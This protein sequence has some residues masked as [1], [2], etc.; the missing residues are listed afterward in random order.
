MTE[1]QLWNSI[2]QMAVTGK[3]V[4]QHPEDEPASALLARIETEKA[5]LIKEKKIKKEKNPTRIVRGENGGFFEIPVVEHSGRSEMGNGKWEMDGAIDISDQIP[6]E[7]PESWEWVRLGNLIEIIS[8]TSYKKHDITDSG[9]RILRG[10][11]IQNNK[12]LLFDDDVFLSEKSID[13]EKNIQKGDIIIVASTGSKA[14]IGKPAF[15][16]ADYPLTQIGAFLRII[17]PI[18]A[19]LVQYIN[20]IFQSE[21]YRKHI[22]DKVKGTNINNIKTEYIEEIFIPLSPLDEQKRIVEKL[23]EIA[24]LVSLY[25]EK[26]RAVSEMDANFAGSLKKSVLAAAVSGKLLPQDA[27]DEPAAALLA[28]IEAE[29]AAL[30]KAKKLKKEKNPTRIVRGKNGGFFEVSLSGHSGRSEMG[31]GKWEMDGA[32]DISDQLPFEIPES[33]EWVRLG[34]IV[35]NHGQKTPTEDFCYIDIGSI[36]NVHQK[37]NEKE[38]IISADKAPSR[39]RKIIKEGDILYATVRPYLHNM[40]IIDRKFSKEAI[41]ST[42]FA[43]LTCHADFLNYFLFYYLMS[44][45][46]D[47]YANSSDN[48]KGV[49]YPAIN[50]DRLYKAFIPIPPL[51]EQERIAARVREI[52]ATLDELH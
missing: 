42:G 41:A 46:F 33:W 49:A 45:A 19:D 17:R 7:I 36:D 4:P 34:N 26:E 25:G 5:A 48:S 43:V 22:R 15:I 27:A 9:I 52:F 44:P 24:P 40:C 14:V 21:Y 51:A 3:L 39:A 31:N 38:N 13:P 16:E 28:R 8:G 30:I 18:N 20:I 32:T 29:K 2:L 47:S 10:G 50:D 1:K 11:N 12:L 6:F 35:Y 37:L 23:G